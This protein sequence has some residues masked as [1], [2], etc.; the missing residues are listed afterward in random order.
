MASLDYSWPHRSLTRK[1]RICFD[2]PSLARQ[3]LIQ[4]HHF[5]DATTK[6][7]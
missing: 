4:S 5:L 3:A 2:I 6:V 7:G 1:R